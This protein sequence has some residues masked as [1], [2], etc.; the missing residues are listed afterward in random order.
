MP[1]S[2]KSEGPKKK[3]VRMSMPFKKHPRLS[4]NNNKSDSSY[5]GSS[6]SG[7]SDSS[8]SELDYVHLYLF[9]E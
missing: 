7:L 1:V 3:I 5:A 4:T 2:E 9:I 6:E 8:E